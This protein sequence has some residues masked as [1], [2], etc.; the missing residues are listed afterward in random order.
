MNNVPPSVRAA[1]KRRG[2]D[3]I[4]N[5]EGE[6]INFKPQID[7]IIHAGEDMSGYI[8]DTESFEDYDDD[9]KEDVSPEEKKAQKA[10]EG[11][12]DKYGMSGMTDEEKDIYESHKDEIEFDDDLDNDVY[13][14]YD[15][16]KDMISNKIFENFTLSEEIDQKTY[17]SLMDYMADEFG[18]QFASDRAS[19]I[20]DFLE[21]QGIRK[22]WEEDLDEDEGLSPM[23]KS[24]FSYKPKPLTDEDREYVKMALEDRDIP[25]ASDRLEEGGLV[26]HFER[27]GH[28]VSD[29]TDKS[30]VVDGRYKVIDNGQLGFDVYDGEK[31]IANDIGNQKDFNTLIDEYESRNEGEAKATSNWYDNLTDDNEHAR[32]YKE[33]AMK[34]NPERAALIA[35][36][37]DEYIA[38]KPERGV[39]T[40]DQL[41]KYGER[42]G[43]PQMSDRDLRLMWNDVHNVAGYR[44]FGT[45]YDKGGREL[46]DAQSAFAEVVNQEARN[47]KAK[48]NYFPYNDE[49][50]EKGKDDI[51]DILRRLDGHDLDDARG[52]LTGDELDKIEG[53]AEQYHLTADDLAKISHHLDPNRMGYRVKGW[54]SPEVLKGK[55]FDKAIKTYEVPDEVMKKY[56][57]E[58]PG[59]N[60]GEKA[61]IK[62]LYM[63]G[64]LK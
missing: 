53:L 32:L 36:A 54:E 40:Y 24:L 29:I 25:D 9:A 26:G 51:R 18:V 22:N 57:K 42:L 28:K 60:E 50:I 31:K 58:F 3:D 7:K 20:D 21:E 6:Y 64:M 45:P 38:E 41:K 59:M 1:L 10:I 5:Q 8:G 52:Y 63:K 49:D 2:A 23:E 34:V 48:G 13:K 43:L 46:E 55:D 12:A 44:G 56:E 37:M 39:I 35:A 14:E 33:D 17:A 16:T 4:L 27:G 30:L 61:L 19:L 62:T 15:L 47:R 11:Y